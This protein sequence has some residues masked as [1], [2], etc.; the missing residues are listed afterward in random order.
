MIALIGLSCI[1]GGSLQ[2]LSSPPTRV[3]SCWLCRR[4][5]R[6]GGGVVPC[7]F[8]GIENRVTASSRG[9]LPPISLPHEYNQPKTYDRT[10]DP[11][12]Y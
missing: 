3:I 6:V 2:I 4:L 7:S 12:G 11:T 1:T 5:F 9:Q 10:Q 8:C